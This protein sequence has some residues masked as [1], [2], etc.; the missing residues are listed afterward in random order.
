MNVNI[1]VI[2]GGQAINYDDENSIESKSDE[3]KN[4]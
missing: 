1:W 4:I 3:K 2:L